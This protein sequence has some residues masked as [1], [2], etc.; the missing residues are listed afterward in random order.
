MVLFATR[1]SAS[2]GASDS[3]ASSLL[4]V[5]VAGSS[6]SRESLVLADPYPVYFSIR[7]GGNRRSSSRG[8][9]CSTGN[10]SRSHFP[11][12][13]PREV[14]ILV[15]SVAVPALGLGGCVP[16]VA[17]SLHGSFVVPWTK[18]LSP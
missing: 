8:V 2:A 17:L 16:G 13:L 12:Y 11:V 15:K 14:E 3:A 6:R 18:A 7:V 10:C 9:G 5:R 1:A 4:A